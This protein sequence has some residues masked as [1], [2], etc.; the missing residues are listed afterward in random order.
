MRAQSSADPYQA[1]LRFAAAGRHADA[2]VSFQAALAQKP[3]DTRTLFALGNTA[4]ALGMPEGACEFFRRVLA[5]EPDRLEAL[6]NL[7]NL[8]RETGQAEAA[9]ALLEPALAR[10]PEAP[11]L[12][13]AL[14]SAH[15]SLDHR[16]EAERHFREALA[17]HPDYPPALGNLADV[18]AD[19]GE[20]D[21]ALALYDRALKRNGAQPQARLNRAVLHF[22][23]G[24]LK[25]GWRD[26][27]A[28]LKLPGK[29]PRRDH[30]IAAWS[31]G[32]LKKSRLLVMVEQGVGDQLMFA[33]CIPGLAA[34]AAET[35]ASVILECEPRLEPLFA[36]SF[37]GVKVMPSDLEA[38]GAVVT[39]RYGWLKSLGGANAATDMGTL[40]RWLRPDLDSFPSAHAYLV[41]DADEKGRWQAWLAEQGTGRFIGI[42]WRSGKSGGDRDLQ[43]APL[44]AWAD[45]L[46]DLNG[47]IVSVQYDATPDEIAELERLSGRAIHMPPGI[48]QKQELDR[49]CALL[50]ALDAVVTAPT[51]VSWLAAGA[52]IPTWKV[53]YDT[54]WTAFGQAHEPFAPACR[55]LMPDE[56]GNWPEVFAKA[57]A[58][59]K[60]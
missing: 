21:E 18:L 43:Y 42:C 49:A 52:G 2:I 35:G 8:L 12:W 5:L 10:A 56:P 20:I 15:R 51:A 36:R 48:D 58:A 29:A 26:Y 33:S 46:R 7:G 45:F 41:P 38:K 11:E 40:P 6:V 28:R 32:P 27:A 23:K 24:N 9:I 25:E 30:R 44:S 34:R 31:G 53:L 39:A 4:R 13:L 59:L 57:R 47:E 60:I 1:G 50:S 55:C 16:G 54:S 22:L 14:G 3:D 37:P 19:R 17:R